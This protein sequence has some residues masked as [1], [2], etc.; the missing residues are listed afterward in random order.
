MIPLIWFLVTARQ[1]QVAAS[2]LHPHRSRWPEKSKGREF[3]TSP[4]E[5]AELAPPLGAAAGPDPS[6]STLLTAAEGLR[7]RVGIPQRAWNMAFEHLGRIGRLITLADLLTFPDN[8]FTGPR[9]AYFQGMINRAKRGEL[10]LDRALY[11]MRSRAQHRAA[12]PGRHAVTVSLEMPAMG[13][14]LPGRSVGELANSLG[15]RLTR[16]RACP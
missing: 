14:R 8:H 6:W 12:D 2:R 5:L 4:E 10:R 3:R 15:A 7:E 9:P 1:G 16:R 13:V 11:G